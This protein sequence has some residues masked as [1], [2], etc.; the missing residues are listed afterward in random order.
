MKGPVIIYL[1]GGGGRQKGVCV[2]GGEGV[3]EKLAI[4]RGGSLLIWLIKQGGGGGV[5]I[6]FKHTL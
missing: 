4:D 3:M 6:F 5:M 2:C 1:Q